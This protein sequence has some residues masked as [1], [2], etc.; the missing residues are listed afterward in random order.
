LRRDDDACARVECSLF[1]GRCRVE[2]QETRDD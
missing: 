2:A 1:E